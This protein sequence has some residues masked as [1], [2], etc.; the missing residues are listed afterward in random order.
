[1]VLLTPGCLH[2]HTRGNATLPGLKT[3]LQAWY[4]ALVFEEAQR[5]IGYWRAIL[6]LAQPEL[7]VRRMKRRWGTCYPLK[8]K[9]V[10][11]MELAKKPREALDYVVLHEMAHFF[12]PNHG[13]DFTHILD[14]RLPGWRKIRS[15]LNGQD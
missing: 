2:I 12:V 7:A 5:R 15:Q 14:A 4:R 6:G 9:I 1:M 13:Q 8:N 10:L 3:R 11:N